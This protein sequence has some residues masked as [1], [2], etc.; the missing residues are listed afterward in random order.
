M[1]LCAPMNGIAYDCKDPDFTRSNWMPENSVS[2]K[3]QRAK[4]VMSHCIYKKD[5][6]K[7]TSVS[8]SFILTALQFRLSENTC[9]GPRFLSCSG[10]S[11]RE[12]KH[13]T[14]LISPDL[15]SKPIST[16]ISNTKQSSPFI[17]IDQKVRSQAKVILPG[18]LPP[19]AGNHPHAPAPHSFRR[20]NL[21]VWQ[22]RKKI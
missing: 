19:L 21:D 13:M 11:S 18:S 4:D 3:Y 22:C 7:E 20:V 15:Q 9:I 1:Y 5:A 8:W 6:P 10:H 2:K 16:Y 12:P 17:S 14:S